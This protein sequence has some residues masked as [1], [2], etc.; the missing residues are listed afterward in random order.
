MKL[1]LGQLLSY[2]LG[3]QIQHLQS[4]RHLSTAK[5]APVFGLYMDELKVWDIYNYAHTQLHH[6]FRL[7][8][9]HPG[10]NGLR[11]RE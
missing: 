2:L 11:F 8:P 5:V 1:G 7:S 4:I 10:V 3:A 6:A 9:D